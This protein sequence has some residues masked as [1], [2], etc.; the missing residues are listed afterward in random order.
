MAINSGT[1]V[2]I[3]LRRQPKRPQEVINVTEQKNRMRDIAQLVLLLVLS[4]VA[5]WSI[6]VYLDAPEEARSYMKMAAAGGVCGLIAL[7]IAFLIYRRLR[8]VTSGR[9]AT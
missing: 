9:T 6:Q 7:V 4:G 3:L 1:Q 2:P 5:T 8:E